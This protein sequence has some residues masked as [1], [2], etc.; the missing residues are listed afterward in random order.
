MGHM[1]AGFKIK[2][3]GDGR[4]FFEAYGYQSI[5]FDFEDMRDNKEWFSRVINEDVLGTVQ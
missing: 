5:P 3:V 1:T 4:F 2:P